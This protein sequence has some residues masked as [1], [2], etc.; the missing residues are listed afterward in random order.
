MNDAATARHGGCVLS[1]AFNLTDWCGTVEFDVFVDP[2]GYLAGQPVL[3][4]LLTVANFVGRFESVRMNSRDIHSRARAFLTD[5]ATRS[6][7]VHMAVPI[8]STVRPLPNGTLRSGPG[9]ELTSRNASP[10]FLSLST[11]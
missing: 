4:I 7:S 3:Q 8:W 9:R 11:V 2:D 5:A 1:M 6:S 10:R